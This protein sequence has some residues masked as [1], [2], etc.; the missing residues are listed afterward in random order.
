MSEIQLYPHKT[1]IQTYTREFVYEL[2]YMVNNNNK[3]FQD[4]LE[5]KHKWK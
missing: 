1:A 4:F 5:I 2:G 3:T